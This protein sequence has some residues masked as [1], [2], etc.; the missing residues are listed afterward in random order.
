MSNGSRGILAS[1][2]VNFTAIYTN[3]NIGTSIN[4]TSGGVCKIKFSDGEYNITYVSDKYVYNRSFSN[5][6][7]K[8]YS[9]TCTHPTLSN[10][11]TM[12]SIVI[13]NNSDSTKGAVSNQTGATPFYTTST[14]PITLTNLRGGDTQTLLWKVNSTGIIGKSYTFFVEGNG[15]YV[16]YNKSKEIN[17]TITSYD[18]TN[19]TII[20]TIITPGII[21]INESV[22]LYMTGSDNVGIKSCTAIITRPG[23][24]NTSFINNLCNTSY[25]FNKTNLTGN[26]LIN[27]S[28]SDFA[29]NT[30]NITKYFVVRKLIN[31]SLNISVDVSF[32]IKVPANRNINITIIYPKTNG[33]IVYNNSVNGSISIQIPDDLF[34]L[35]FDLFNNKLNILLKNINLSD[36]SKKNID[37]NEVNESKYPTHLVTYGIET[38]LNF[39][40]AS[41]KIYYKGLKYNHVNNLEL[42][43]CD[44][45][46]FTTSVCGVSGFNNTGASANSVGEYFE[47]STNSFSGFAII[48][49][50]PS[51]E[52]NNSCG[53]GG[54]GVSS[55]GSSGSREYELLQL[56]SCDFGY[57]L[58]D[59][60]TECIYNESYFD[61]L[62]KTPHVNITKELDDKSD[63][64]ETFDP[65][66]S[67]DSIEIQDDLFDIKFELD[68]VVIE[69]S[70]DL[71]SIITFEKFGLTPTLVNFEINIYDSQNNV[72]FTNK[73]SR[74]VETDELFSET[75]KDLNILKSDN[76]IIELT[77]EYGNGKIDKFTQHFTIVEEELNLLPH[78]LLI[79]IL[80]LLIFVGIYLVIKYKLNKTYIIKFN[81]N[82]KFSNK[83]KSK[84]PKQYLAE[85]F[86]T[87]STHNNDL[88]K[89]SK[90]LEKNKSLKKSFEDKLKTNKHKIMNSLNNFYNKKK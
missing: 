89:L 80:L 51:C 32:G 53:G 18:V 19:P 29:G 21:G 69:N 43:K 10:L 87:S 31:Y 46:N 70:H 61:N 23:T 36:E 68:S 58:N 12:S 62:Y 77:T 88:I 50:E 1:E 33:V 82:Y 35:K 73:Y 52:D 42:Y 27:F 37:F 11:T 85:R 66:V 8:E 40:N 14:N 16:D 34:H 7:L 54:S 3:T 72:V 22:N 75:Y 4:T 44:D 90:E 24:S 9:I 17:L 78:N 6:G 67:N 45:W 41:V 26:Y 38:S 79:G 59:D 39:T 84:N 15:T 74:F 55:G 71:I 76:Y 47:L 2:I 83:N 13:S 25:T 57:D 56:D 81:R 60:K 49:S 63:F 5:P 64:I 30:K 20:S 65:V 28:I 48:E 86:I